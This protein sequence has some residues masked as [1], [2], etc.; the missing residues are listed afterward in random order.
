MRLSASNLKRRN[1]QV[2]NVLVQ[3]ERLTE[4][5]AKTRAARR[6]I[7]IR[8]KLKQL[9]KAQE[10]LSFSTADPNKS[11]PLPR[12][13]VKARLERIEAARRVSKRDQIRATFV[14]GGAPGGG[15]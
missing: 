13:Y 9:R 2:R 5:L 15:H 4:E 10:R 12:S 3:I 1:S 11:V 14:Q 7:E 6:Q 8:A